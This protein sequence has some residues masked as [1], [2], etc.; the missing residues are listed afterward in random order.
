MAENKVPLHLHVTIHPDKHPAIYAALISVEPRS[1]VYHLTMISETALGSLGSARTIEPI[2]SLSAGA[3]R[4]STP[5][6][7]LGALLGFTGAV[8]G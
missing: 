6:D 3:A 2:Q 7:D 5:V 1:R 8:S 4:A